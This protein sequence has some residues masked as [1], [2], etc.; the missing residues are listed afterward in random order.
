MAFYMIE[1][2]LVLARDASERDI[3]AVMTALFEEL[4]ASGRMESLELQGM[5]VLFVAMPD[6]PADGLVAALR[7]HVEALAEVNV[8]RYRCEPVASMG[9]SDLKP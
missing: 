9:L 8:V 3:E 7:P 6:G 2:N 5:T 4:T 1:G